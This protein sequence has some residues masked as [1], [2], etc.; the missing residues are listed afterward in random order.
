[1]GSRLI[2]GCTLGVLAC[3]AWAL[4][5]LPR[6]RFDAAPIAA[7]EPAAEPAR[8]ALTPLDL[9]AFRAPLWVAPPPPPPAP[10]PPA[11]APPPPPLKLQLL[12]VVSEGGVYKAALYDPDAD[13]ITIAGPGDTIAG[14]TIKEVRAGDVTLTDGGKPRTLSLRP[15]GSTP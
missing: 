4:R 10:A 8:L 9:A 13:R 7:S 15:E 2:I 12:A 5:P 1:V 6:D 14:R 3:A 11:P